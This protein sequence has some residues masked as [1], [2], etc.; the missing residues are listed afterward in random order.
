MTD[1]RR[2]PIA[3]TL[4]P[5][6]LPAR[7]QQWRDVVAESTGRDEVEGGVR[8]RFDRSPGLA[9]RL[10]DLAEAEHGCCGFFD[11]AIALGPDGTSL[12]VTAP[13]EARA[14]VDALLGHRSPD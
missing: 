8:L 2:I 3:C 6:D 4:E 12:T 14:M 13:P 9:A 5:S 1:R 10:A 7:L 11:F